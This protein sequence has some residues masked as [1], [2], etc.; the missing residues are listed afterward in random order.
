MALV[1]HLSAKGVTL[2]ILDPDIN[3]GGPMG[4]LVLTMLGA[5]AEFE[6]AIMLERQREGIAKARCEGK[7]KGRKPTACEG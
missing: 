3:T 2:R 5:I 4:K 6:R 7:L 1:E